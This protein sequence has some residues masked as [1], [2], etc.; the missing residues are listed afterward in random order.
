MEFLAHDRN[1]Q[2][3]VVMTKLLRWGIS[4]IVLAFVLLFLVR[5]HYV[6]D[7]KSLET[8]I[9]TELPRGTSKTQ[10]IRFIETRKPL[11]WDDQDRHVKARITGR[12]GNLIYRK[13]IVLDFEFD[14]A[15]ELLSWSE[16][17]YLTFL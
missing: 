5:S 10:V 6:L 2:E 8:A 4:A 12:A 17:E 11:F 7:S 13:D 14:S 15:G 16:K 9:K 1:V 3:A